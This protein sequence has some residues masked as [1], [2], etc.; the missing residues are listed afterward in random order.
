MF[1]FVWLNCVFRND[2]CCVIVVCVGMR[3]MDFV[4]CLIFEF[5]GIFSFCCVGDSIKVVR[6]VCK[7]FIC[8][9]GGVCL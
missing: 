5:K 1:F 7:E 2:W 8:L 9:I 6:V 3:Y 4:I